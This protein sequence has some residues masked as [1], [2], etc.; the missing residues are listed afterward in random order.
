MSSGGRSSQ[1]LAA[2]ALGA[3]VAGAAGWQEWTAAGEVPGPRYGHSLHTFR[4]NVYLFG[5]RCGGT[6]G[7][8]AACTAMRRH[9]RL[10][11]GTQGCAAA[12]R[13]VRRHAARRVVRRHARL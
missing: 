13:V 11:G 6:Q 7:C 12:R 1:A 10:C 4:N 5:G 2:L 9:A 3:M 8:A